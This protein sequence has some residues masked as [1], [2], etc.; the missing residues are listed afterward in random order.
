M[1]YTLLIWS[2]PIFSRTVG[3]CCACPESV[4]TTDP[5]VLPARKVVVAL[6]CDRGPVRPLRGSAFG[7]GQPDRF[8]TGAFLDNHEIAVG[9]ARFALHLFSQR[10]VWRWGSVL[11]TVA[12][13]ALAALRR[14]PTP[15]PP[16]ASVVVLRI[17]AH[18]RS[19]GLG[20]NTSL[21]PCATPLRP[22]SQ[23]RRPRRLWPRG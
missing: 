4:D 3:P 16:V 21:K 14:I 1:D 11:P 17:Q 15:P 22:S 8:A 5:T 20:R 19:H 7:F 23:S 10:C 9:V 12:Q 18:M 2:L 6:A 13:G